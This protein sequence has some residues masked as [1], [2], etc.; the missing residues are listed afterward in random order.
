MSDATY[1]PPGPAAPLVAAPTPGGAAPGGP[2]PDGGGPARAALG[3][4]RT[5]V[6]KAVVAAGEVPL[7][8]VAPAAGNPVV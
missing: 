3:R 6:A 8:Q 1:T 2:G 4:L 7:R 5:E